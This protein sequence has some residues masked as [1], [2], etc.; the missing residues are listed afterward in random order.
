MYM[1]HFYRMMNSACSS[2]LPDLIFTNIN[3]KV[4][5]KDNIMVQPTSIMCCSLDK[6]KVST[7]KQHLR[8]TMTNIPPDQNSI[9]PFGG[10]AKFDESAVCP[11]YI[12]HAA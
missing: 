8:D 3:S 1:F 10:L 5:A 11:Y 7:C 6:V 12:A 9:I 4:H 2:Y